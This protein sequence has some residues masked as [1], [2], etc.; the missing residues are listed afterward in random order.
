MKFAKKT[1]VVYDNTEADKEWLKC[2]NAVIEACFA[3]VFFLTGDGNGFDI[4]LPSGPVQEST[5]DYVIRQNL[6]LQPI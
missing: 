3:W 5:S 2:P 1:M 4:L 6:Q